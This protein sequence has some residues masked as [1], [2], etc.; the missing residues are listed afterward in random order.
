[1]TSQCKPF[2][3]YHC[4]VESKSHHSP[5]NFLER[6]CK[7]R[8]SIPSSNRQQKIRRLFRSRKAVVD[9]SGHSHKLVG[10]IL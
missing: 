4:P 1:M 10:G 6:H 2:A 3:W 8:S 9:T 5:C 7:N